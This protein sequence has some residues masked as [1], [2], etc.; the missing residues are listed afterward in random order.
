MN[1]LRLTQ[2]LDSVRL[3]LRLLESGNQTLET[4]AAEELPEAVK[5]VL[6]YLGEERLRKVEALSREQM[7]DEWLAYAE[8]CSAECGPNP[9]EYVREFYPERFKEW[10][11][12]LDGGTVNVPNR[13]EA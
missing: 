10:F 12:D 4:M 3:Q 8:G 6:E 11:P 2:M 7:M 5:P 9:D 13:S 1:A